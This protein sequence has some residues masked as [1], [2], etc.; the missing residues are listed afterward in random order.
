MV[1]T[2]CC[3]CGVMPAC[4]TSGACT[5]VVVTVSSLFLGSSRCCAA[6]DRVRRVLDACL[7]HALVATPQARHQRWLG[8]CG[9]SCSKRHL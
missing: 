8:G 5:V 9:V 3:T 6:G 4:A 1:P 7:S 2:S